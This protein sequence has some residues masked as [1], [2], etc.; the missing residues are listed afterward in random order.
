MDKIFFRAFIFSF[1][2]FISNCSLAQEQSKIDSLKVLLES[3]EFETVKVDLF[4][5]LSFEFL[6]SC[7]DTSEVYAIRAYSLSKKIAYQKGIAESLINIGNI[8]NIDGNFYKAIEQFLK[9]MKIFQ[10]INDSTGIALVYFRLGITHQY[11]SNFDKTL[12]Y[13]KMA[14]DISNK[15]NKKDVE[16]IYN[17]IGLAYFLTDQIDSALYYFEKSI[18]T[19]VEFNNKTG[20]IYSYGNIA[21]IY[22]SQEKFE[23]AL[24]IYIKVGRLCEELDDKIGLSVSHN[25]ISLIYIELAEQTNDESERN[26]YFKL[27]VKNAQYS[28]KFAEEVNSLTHMNFAYNNLQFSYKGLKDFKNACDFA[29][30]YINTTD[31]L[32]TVNKIKE[33]ENIE[34]K[35]KTEQQKIKIESILKEKELNEAV[36][37]KK[38]QIIL[39]GTFAIFLILILLVFLFILYRNKKKTN[40][41]LNEKNEAIKDQKSE[42]A[43]QRDTLS[44]LAFELKKSNKTK[45]KYFSIFAHDL[46]NPFQSILGFS[47]LLLA[48]SS[49][50]DFSNSEKYAKYIF[51][52]TNKTYIL[53]ENLLNWARVQR[54]AIKYQADTY[55]LQDLINECI[56]ISEDPAKSKDILLSSDIDPAVEIYADKY[57]FSTV[58]RNLISNAVK[59]TERGGKITIKSEINEPGKIDILVIDTGIGI[60]EDSKSKIFKLDYSSSTKGTENESGTGLGLVVCKEFAK[61]NKGKLKVKSKVGEGSTFILTIPA[62]NEG[63]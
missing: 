11:L 2:I 32:Y 58:I 43:A 40:K 26:N 46:K 31:S 15:I 16:N 48:Q 51:D 60:K 5:E 35:Y 20:V 39:T 3:T 59:F 34:K 30:K 36:I 52:T 7:K 41:L 44:E 12:E 29:E 50:G 27:A 42:I 18:I 24:D 13:S 17:S 45:D 63:L 53:L 14:L 8:S 19:A 1:L 49:K 10:N 21:N 56:E 38:D 55:N 37:K 61:K 33:I 9:A 47:E 22:Y 54:G 57:M 25:N 6:Y 62:D 23:K 28:L 4:N